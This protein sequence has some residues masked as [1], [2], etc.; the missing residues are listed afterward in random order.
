MAGE[1][2]GAAETSDIHADTPRPRVVFLVPALDSPQQQ[3]EVVT[4][5][6]EF[7]APESVETCE[8]VIYVGQ[9]GWE[10]TSQVQSLTSHLMSTCR[11]HD[12]L[13]SECC[14]L[15]SLHD[16]YQAIQLCLARIN[17]VRQGEFMA[18]AS[19]VLDVWNAMYRETVAARTLSEA[20]EAKD[21]EGVNHL[22]ASQESC[23]P[24][25][26][27]LQDVIRDYRDFLA[28]SVCVDH[29]RVFE[30]LR[31][32]LKDDP[33]LFRDAFSKVYIIEGLELL[34]LMERELLKL[35]FDGSQVYRVS[36]EVPFSIAA[37]PSPSNLNISGIHETSILQTPSRQDKEQAEE[38]DN[39][40]CKDTQNPQV[41]H[42]NEQT[43]EKDNDTDNSKSTDAPQTPSSHSKH[44]T[45]QT[46]SM[47][48]DT[49]DADSQG[50]G[51]K[52]IIQ[53]EKEENTLEDVINTT[54]PRA[55]KPTERSESEEYVERLILAHLRLLIN[56]R[57]ELA[58]TLACSMPGREITHQG[59]TDIR[60][61]AQRKEMPMY[62][63]IV[64]FILRLR[65]GGKGYQPEPNNPVLPHAKPLG[66]FVDA[67]MK[68]QNILEAQTDSRQGALR[69]LNGIKTGL[70]KMKGCLLKRSV[71]GAVTDRLSA[72]LRHLME[73]A[74]GGDGAG[75]GQGYSKSTK[76][77]TLHPSL[78]HLIRLCDVVGGQVYTGGVVDALGGD[79]LT[80][81]SSSKKKTQTP[82]RIPSV[83][84]LF[85]SPAEVLQEKG[86]K[87]EEEEDL[88]TRLK[89]KMG[90][91]TT[92]AA[93]P[94]R[95]K[96]DC[97]WAPVDL[98]PIHVD[99]LNFS[100][101]SPI[102][103]PS[104]KV[105]G[106]A[107][108]RSEDWRDTVAS[109]TQREESAPESQTSSSP[110][111]SSSLATPKGPKAG[112]NKSKKVKS[113][114]SLLKDISNMAS[115]SEETQSKKQKAPEVKKAAPKKRK[116]KTKPL[117]Q[118]QRSITSFF[119]S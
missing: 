46:D 34:P 20:Q 42:D 117:L 94:K 10:E 47:E 18:A 84:N 40:Y 102:A 49:N 29:F 109:V 58:L 63:T 105:V 43:D 56:T 113:K 16:Q 2:C 26:K 19:D 82:V 108:K 83:L 31:G 28:N 5:I 77:S 54:A 50:K 71:I 48:S 45:N 68:L 110:C 39:A 12:L 88:E 66:E 51:I 13:P 92:A 59:F 7:V 106:N 90:K 27:E 97:S 72:A 74:E 57:D 55:S 38:I 33:V 87:G 76:P 86:E 111:K 3:Q 93:Q 81:L 107:A 17:K 14:V 67:L 119:K 96:S 91:A 23:D 70:E 79:L 69:V 4:K 44:Q 41:Q 8:G 6:Q 22:T 85:R 37:P 99:K 1:K 21:L 24:L 32:L 64:S 118:G 11:R 52:A 78:K 35:I 15:L 62:Q 36:V 9:V 61:E 114:R 89:R 80:Q 75:A 103:G 104:L 101:S 98:S 73:A 60:Q 112:D 65:L 53:V 116:E 95:Y 100:T 30:C 25:K 115:K